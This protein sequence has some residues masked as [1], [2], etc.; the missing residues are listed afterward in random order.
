LSFA[1]FDFKYSFIK[2]NWCLFFAWVGLSTGNNNNEAREKK[3]LKI[4]KMKNLNK[5]IFLVKRNNRYFVYVD[6]KLFYQ[7]HFLKSRDLHLSNDSFTFFY[8]LKVLSRFGL[9]K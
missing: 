5:S 6:G 2:K 1:Y 7:Q 3:I 4:N 8:V 9:A